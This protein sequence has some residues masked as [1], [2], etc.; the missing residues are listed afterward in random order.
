MYVYFCFVD[1]ADFVRFGNA[2][3]AKAFRA[4]RE[5]DAARQSSP[6]VKLPRIKGNG[7]HT[8]ATI[9]FIAGNEHNGALF[10][11]RITFQQINLTT[12]HC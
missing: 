6:P 11:D 10:A 5:E 4:G 8:M 7:N 2:I 9:Q 3:F 12:L 1:K